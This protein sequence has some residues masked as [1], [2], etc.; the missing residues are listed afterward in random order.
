MEYISLWMIYLFGIYDNIK[1]LIAIFLTM[2]L[3]ASILFTLSYSLEEE[4]K[5]VLKYVKI[6]WVIFIVLSIIL[7][8]LPSRNILI[9]MFILEPTKDIVKSIS[10]S[11]RTKMITETIDNYILYINKKAKELRNE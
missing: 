8:L 3:I 2:S 7:S 9:A 11:N 6:S 10:D 5:P 4:D 1:T